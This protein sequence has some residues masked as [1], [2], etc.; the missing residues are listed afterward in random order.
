MYEI[1][2]RRIY[3]LPEITIFNDKKEYWVMKDFLKKLS[4]IKKQHFKSKLVKIV[5]KVELPQKFVSSIYITGDALFIKS[6]GEGDEEELNRYC[7][8][9]IVETKI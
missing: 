8:G 3:E 9:Q 1:K 6:K 4:K 2:L 5:E 7:I